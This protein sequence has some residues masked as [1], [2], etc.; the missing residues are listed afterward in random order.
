MLVDDHAVVREGYRAVLQ[1]QPG[2]RVVAEAADGAEAYRLFKE[3]KPDLVIMDL[4]M[5]GIGGIEAIRRIRQ[6]DRHARILVFTM[7][8]NA[9][10]AVQAIRAGA[11]GYVTK[12]SPPETLVQ[13]ALDVLIGRIAIS[14][15]IDHEL[16]LS[17]LAG[18][19]VAADVLSPREFEVLR[20]LLAERTGDEIAD[21]L[22]I[23][24]KTVANLH[25]LIKTK[26]GVG[27]D[28]ELVR[29]AL[30]QGILSQRDWGEA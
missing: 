13:A 25:Y 14:P 29:L 9:A 16:A 19:V 28:I 7:H 5:P 30:R 26:L 18:E 8:Q 11:R 22:H 20:M 23:S 12:T 17:R 15:D 10:F 6:W 1:K 2:L 4:A 24:P 3:I 21:M 27:S